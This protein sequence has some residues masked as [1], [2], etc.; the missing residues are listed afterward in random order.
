MA[1]TSK[2]DIHRIRKQVKDKVGKHSDPTEFR[3][4]KAEDGA[5]PIQSRFFILPPFAEGDELATGNAEQGMEEF[6]L[7]NGSHYIDNK[8]LGCPRVINEGKCDICQHGFDLMKETENKDERRD[9]AKRLL[10]GTYMMVNIYFPNIDKNPENLRGQV[11]WYNCPK[12]VF[13]MWEDCLFRDDDGGDPQEPLP[14]L[15]GIFG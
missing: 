1:R 14:F 5:P 15:G 11:R 12:T 6:F 3:P 10:P 8:R 9:I 2:Y 4:P 13:D 7:R